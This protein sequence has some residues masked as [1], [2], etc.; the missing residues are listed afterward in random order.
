MAPSSLHLKQIFDLHS[1]AT[2]LTSLIFCRSNCLYL[3]R[4]DGIVFLLSVIVYRLAYF[5]LPVLHAEL[6][7]SKFDFL[8]WY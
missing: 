5:M 8:C 4:V 6:F 2:A 3:T 7:L 1:T